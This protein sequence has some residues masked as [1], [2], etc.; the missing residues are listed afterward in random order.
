MAQ[1]ASLFSVKQQ[2]KKI[3]AKNEDILLSH[4]PA[5]KD[6]LLPPEMVELERILVGPKI[7]DGKEN[8]HEEWYVVVKSNETADTSIGIPTL[9]TRAFQSLVRYL[10]QNPEEL[11]MAFYPQALLNSIY[12]T[13][14]RIPCGLIFGYDPTLYHCV[15]PY[16][17]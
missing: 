11:R 17:V 6:A 10:W 14:G 15:I 9:S 7:C 8:E 2:E 12:V 3:T 13:W 16:K 1:A 4:N 5:K